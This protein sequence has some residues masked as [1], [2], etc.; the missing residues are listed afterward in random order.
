MLSLLKN[1]TFLLFGVIYLIVSIVIL[2]QPLFNY[3]GF[4]FSAL[5]G[6]IVFAVSSNYTYKI[7]LKYKNKP[8]KNNFTEMVIEALYKNMMLIIIPFLAATINLFFVRNCSY[9]TGVFY[10]L[11]IPCITVIYSIALSVFTYSF[12]NRFRRIA[13]TAIFIIIILFSISEYYFNPQLFVF[14]PFIGFFPGMIYDEEL[15]LTSNLIF[16]RI[17]TLLQSIIL[18][19]VANIFYQV[20]DK[21]RLR[22]EL[23]KLKYAFQPIVIVL[24]FIVV[25]FFVFRNEFRI[26][27]EKDYI[28]STL[29]KT[30]DTPHFIIHY[31]SKN[32]SEKE[33]ND[34]CDLH[35][36]YYYKICREL[37]VDFTD[38]IESFIYPDPE[39]KY[40]LIGAKYTIIAKPWLKQIHLNENSIDEVLKHELV[41]VIAGNFGIPVLRVSRSA[42]LVEGL[43]MAIEWQWGYRTLHQYS[44]GIL[45]FMPGINFSDILSTTGFISSNPNIS[46]V[47]SGSFIRYLIDNYGIRNVKQL[48][49]DGDYKKATGK[50]EDILVKEWQS[51]LYK[52]N[53]QSED[54][55]VTLYTFKRQSIFQKVCAR[56]IANL[57]EEANRELRSGNY[58][59]SIELFN[60]SISLSNNNEAKTGLIV[61]WLRSGDY[62][63]VTS[64]TG[65]LI[66]DQKSKI[67]FLPLKL[68]YADALWQKANKEKNERLYDSAYK[69]CN[70]VFNYH[71]NENYD[72]A[73]KSRMSIIND[74]NLRLSMLEYYAGFKDDGLKLLL[75]SEVIGKNPDFD[76]GKLMIARLLYY[77]QDYTRSVGYLTKIN[78]NFLSGFFMGEKYRLL[79]LGYQKTGEYEKALGSFERALDFINNESSRNE[80]IELA[81]RTRFKQQ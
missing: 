44:Y 49:N 11:L 63:S 19:S 35:E 69:E 4:E 38:K 29:G 22:I 16:Y 21:T 45:K 71:L 27:V 68:Y 67:Y 32:L 2:F 10:Y 37:E 9:L 62:D 17:N 70:D 6:L 64:F 58:P 3:L 66:N 46:Y 40:S 26:T 7:F 1:K 47:L 61:S 55:T 13:L 79:G 42:A 15:Y 31:S 39:T 77:K 14:N 20:P 81:E 56:V 73:A 41:H 33:V 57:N 75:L 12:F 78:D 18:L 5:N 28:I 60:R 54:S 74:K 53:V 80:V 65:K 43:A 30:R 76:L 8:G 36:F 72:F 48:Y 34:I 23:M 50:S 59:K 24:L 25:L 51:Y 52:I